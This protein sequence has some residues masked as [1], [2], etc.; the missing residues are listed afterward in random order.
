MMR[1]DQV[2]KKIVLSEKAYNSLNDKLYTLEVALKASKDEIKSAIKNVFSVDVVKINTSILRG[3][4][5]RKARSKKASPVT[6]K[7][8]NV[9]KAFVRLKAG[10][11]LPVPQVQ[12]EEASSAE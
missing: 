7:S 11:E 10:Q 6:I 3:K 1:H 12:K 2:I 5:R 8:A 9:K 4:E